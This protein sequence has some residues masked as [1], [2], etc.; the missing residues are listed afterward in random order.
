MELH[1]RG[2]TYSHTDTPVEMTDNCVI[3]HYRGASAKICQPK[4]EATK[5]LAVALRYRGAWVR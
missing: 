2:A 4:Q 3:G 1:Y 5:R